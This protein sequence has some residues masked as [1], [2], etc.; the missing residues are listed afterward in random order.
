MAKWS[1]TTLVDNNF[2]ADQVN[3]ALLDLL[4][5]DNTTYSTI[6]TTCTFKAYSASLT[7]PSTVSTTIPLPQIFL[8]G[9]G[10]YNT[11]NGI[12][13]VAVAGIYH[14]AARAAKTAAAGNN[15][16][17][18]QNTT[19]STLATFAGAAYTTN[20]ETMLQCKVGDKLSLC[21]DGT[22]LALTN[23]ALEIDKVN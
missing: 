3:K 19:L 12:Y 15:L 2:T 23:V 10:S 8:T 17:V 14:I 22:S 6:P 11:T 5:K 16:Q 18:L 7:S 9:L 13:T 4:A 1:S 21:V 20:G